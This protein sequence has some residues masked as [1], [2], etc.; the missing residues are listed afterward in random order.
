MSNNMEDLH[1]TSY[2][3]SYLDEYLFY[4]YRQTTHC[5]FKAA[6]DILTLNVKGK[7]L[8]WIKRDFTFL[9]KLFFWPC[10][11]FFKTPFSP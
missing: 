6:S 9:P 11:E 8:N 5:V 1:V 10:G 4:I 3:F 2:C 7:I